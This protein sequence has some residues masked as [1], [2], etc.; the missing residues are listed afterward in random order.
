MARFTPRVRPKSSAFTMRWG[1][2]EDTAELRDCGTAELST[3]F[4]VTST[5]TRQS[6]LVTRNSALETLLVRWLWH[7]G[8]RSGGIRLLERLD[9]PPDVGGVGCVRAALQVPAEVLQRAGIIPLHQ[10]DASEQR[11][12]LR[13]AVLPIEGCGLARAA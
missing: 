3:E 11:L 13:Q 6:E 4:R 1:T 5:E 2:D 7:S 12:D 8:C 10:Q 9:L